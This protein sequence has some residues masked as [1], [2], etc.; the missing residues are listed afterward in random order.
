VTQINTKARNRA[1]LAFIGLLLLFLVPIVAAIVMHSIGGGV[2]TSSTVNRGELVK[3]VVPVGEHV[4]LTEQG[5][6][7][8]ADYFV[9][10]WTMVYMDSGQCNEACQANLYTIRQSRLALGGEKERVQRLMVLTDGKVSAGLKELLKEHAGMDVVSAQ[11]LTTFRQVFSKDGTGDTTGHIYIVDP[12]GNLM[13]RYPLNM[14]PKGLIKD[15]ERLLK[16]S[17]IG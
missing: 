17:R 15:M 16:Y 12:L 9:G 11:S 14:E 4:L 10:K 5:E 13:M 7:L 6:A 8:P 1:R 2:G 3:P